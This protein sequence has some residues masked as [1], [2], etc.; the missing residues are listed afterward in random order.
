MRH[1]VETAAANLNWEQLSLRLSI[2]E[3][4]MDITSSSTNSLSKDVPDQH[5]RTL[6]RDQT[7]HLEMPITQVDY[8]RVIRY[9]GSVGQL[10]LLLPYMMPSCP[11]FPGIPYGLLAEHLSADGSEAQLALTESMKR[12]IGSSSQG[13]FCKLHDSFYSEHC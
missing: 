10:R 12:I 4:D 3:S 6:I 1:N 8:L 9:L 11:K 7:G 2:K 5:W 13:R